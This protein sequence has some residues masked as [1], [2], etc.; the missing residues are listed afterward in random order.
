MLVIV[1]EVRVRVRD[2]DRDVMSLRSPGF[3]APVRDPP[4][5]RPDGVTME[6]LVVGRDVMDGTRVVFVGVVRVVDMRLERV[7]VGVV[8]RRD[9]VFELG[10]EVVREVWLE[11]GL[12]VSLVL[13]PGV[14]LWRAVVGRVLDRVVR[15]EIPVLDRVDVGV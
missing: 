6:R 1:G 12:E 5:V 11:L 9:V 15:D 13:L 2:R 10:T 8:N 14:E 3:C 7:E 4:P